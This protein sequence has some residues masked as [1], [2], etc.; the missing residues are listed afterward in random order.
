[1]N[2]GLELDRLIARDVMGYGT[3]L[4]DGELFITLAPAGVHLPCPG[5]STDIAS[6]WLVVDR[7]QQ[8]M[9][10]VGSFSLHGG[11]SDWHCE[12]DSN[13]GRFLQNGPTINAYSSAETPAHSICLAALAAIASIQS[14]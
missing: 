12:I 2:P 8:I 5:Y 9:S 14:P 13:D 6:A 4:E 10:D 11:R 1:M 3:F 7:L